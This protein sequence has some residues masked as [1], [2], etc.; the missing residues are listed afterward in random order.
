MAKL[1]NKALRR[2]LT[3]ANIKASFKRTGIWPINFDALVNDM[4]PSET[5]DIADTD[6]AFAVQNILS[7]SGLDVSTDELSQKLHIPMDS[8]EHEGV[9]QQLEDMDSQPTQEEMGD[10][11]FPTPTP[12]PPEQTMHYYVVYNNEI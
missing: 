6:D 4:H 11:T 7:L 10:F 5:Y 8:Q 3:P 2:V 9:E 1:G 12:T